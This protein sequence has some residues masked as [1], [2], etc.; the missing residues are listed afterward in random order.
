MTRMSG[1]TAGSISTKIGP[2]EQFIHDLYDLSDA[3]RTALSFGRLSFSKTIKTGY[4]RLFIDYCLLT[5][6]D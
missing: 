2:V 1:K 5:T 6:V 4:E 3:V